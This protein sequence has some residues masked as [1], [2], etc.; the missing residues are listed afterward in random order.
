MIRNC[1]SIFLAVVIAFTS[2]CYPAYASTEDY[3]Q[4][5]GGFW[6]WVG[7]AIVGAATAEVTRIAVCA[8]IIPEFPLAA[9]PCGAALAAE[10]AGAATAVTSKVI[11][12]T[13][14]NLIP[15]Y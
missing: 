9:A 6:S 1:L 10:S 5:S 15:A 4:E 3:N 12:E 7:T 8:V 13:A 2:I 11:Q 14:K